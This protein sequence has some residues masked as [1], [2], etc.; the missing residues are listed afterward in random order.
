MLNHHNPNDLLSPLR[1]KLPLAMARLFYQWRLRSVHLR[2][3]HVLLGVQAQLW[4]LHFPCPVPGIF[5]ADCVFVLCVDWY[6]VLPSIGGEEEKGAN[7]NDRVDRFLFYLG[8]C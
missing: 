6:A 4:R 3:H 2:H 8:V 1:R 5:S 7:V